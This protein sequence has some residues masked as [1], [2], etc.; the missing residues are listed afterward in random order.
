MIYKSSFSHSGVSK[1]DGAPG[2]GSGRYPLGSGK[3]PYK[4]R[5]GPKIG[6][7]KYENADGTLTPKGE[8]RLKKEQHKNS[9]QK[10]KNQ[11]TDE[12]V[13]DV[14]RWVTDD[15]ERSQQ[16]ARAGT[17]AVKQLQRIEQET[18]PRPVKERMDLSNMTD[19][20]LRQRINRELTERQYN[21][22]F[23]KTSQPK[24]SKG[25]KIVSD[26]LDVAGDVM[27]VGTSALTIALLI[28]KLKG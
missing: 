18:R 28:K 9:L 12:A 3:S 8:K 25:R 19:Q 14:D 27:A 2:R 15:L 10:H 23:G 20:E 5:G 1:L 13:R 11:L 24:I 6:K 17:D 16:I 26:A 22:L 4:H 7:R 21:D